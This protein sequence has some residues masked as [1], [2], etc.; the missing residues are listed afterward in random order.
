M[1][2]K[3]LLFI[4]FVVALVRA[5]SELVKVFEVPGN[6]TVKKEAVLNVL[7]LVYD[8]AAR[9]FDLPLAKERAM[10]I[11]GALIDIVVAVYNALGIFRKSPAT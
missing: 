2:E 6:G 5:I 7:G 1:L 8:E 11:A 4:G 10:A 3:L 9:I